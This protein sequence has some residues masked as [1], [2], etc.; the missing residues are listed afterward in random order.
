MDGIQYITDVSQLHRLLKQQVKK[1]SA[2]QKENACLRET[3]AQ[4]Q[5]KIE[6]LA[7][8]VEHLQQQLD[9]LLRQV[10]GTKSERKKKKAGTEDNKDYINS[11]PAK[12]KTN[13]TFSTQQQ[14][15]ESREDAMANLPHQRIEHD[16]SDVEKYCTVCEKA[17]DKI[18]EI[19]KK[20]LDYI[21]AQLVVNEHI[22]FTYACRHCHGTIHTAALPPQP[23]DKGLASPSL[24]ASLLTDKYQDHLPLYRQQQRWARLG[25]PLSR[26]TL[27][28]WVGDCAFLFELIVDQMAM[29]LLQRKKIHTDDTTLPILAKIKTHT[30]RLWIYLADGD[31]QSAIAVYDYTPTRAQT[32]PQLFLKDYQGYLQ[33]DAYPGYDK[34]YDADRIIEVACWA[35]ARRK[36]HDIV[37]A[38]GQPGLADKAIDFI[39]ELYRIEAHI[40]TMSFY[41][42]KYYRRH[43]A[44][45]IL[46]K[47]RRWLKRSQE[48]TLPQSAIGKAIAYAL[49]QWQ[50]LNNYLREGYLEIDN[51]RAERAIKPL[52]IGRKNY[53]FCGSHQGGQRAATIYSLI[54]TCKLNGINTFHYL[55]D[56][57]TRIATT[58]ASKVK[59]LVPYNWQPL[60]DLPTALP[61]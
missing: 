55:Y 37:C 31:N 30:G 35:H 11:P 24:L 51:N 27:C 33:A 25:V 2:L 14:T 8:R 45:P 34:L 1:N 48:K 42:R 28:D 21:P 54:E 4:Q 7:H 15:T 9:Q 5:C 26:S 23:I 39:A 60:H 20:Q 19:S 3:V 53:L 10:Y 50:G 52:V 58:P 13:A 46:K 56:V 49:N 6:Q 47:F 43:Y 41:R 18:G 12:S 40:K 59:E 38:T 16:I 44:K 17:L 61:A 29:D 36:F 32:G 22:R 57:L